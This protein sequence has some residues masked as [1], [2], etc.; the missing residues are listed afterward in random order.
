MAQEQKQAP[1]RLSIKERTKQRPFTNDSSLEELYDLADIRNLTDV[2]QTPER[3]T[4]MDRR[5][6][7]VN[8]LRESY[9]LASEEDKEAKRKDLIRAETQLRKRK[10]DA[11]KEHAREMSQLR[12]ANEKKVE[13]AKPH[14]DLAEIASLFPCNRV[15]Q[16]E[17]AVTQVLQPATVIRW[18]D[19]NSI[20]T[21]HMEDEPVTKN[22]AVV[23]RTDFDYTPN[24]N[25][26]GVHWIWR[27]ALA[28]RQ[29]R[30]RSV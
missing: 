11:A 27:I 24:L 30:A 16:L 26:D 19:T 25:R 22:R 14:W 12:K 1:A 28:V 2:F 7:L 13:E 20:M 29:A 17:N 21:I 10:S 23:I 18:D 15:I 8:Y 9:R 4:I 3:Y 6:P 5:K